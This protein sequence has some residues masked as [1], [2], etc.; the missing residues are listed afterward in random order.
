MRYLFGFFITVG[1]IILL[2]VLLVTGGNKSKVPNTSKTLAS[3]ANSTAVVRL[4]I[5][6]PINSVQDHR[7]SRITVGR[8]NTTYEQLQG[9]DGNVTLLQ[10]YPNTPTSYGTFLRAIALAGFT[11]GDT[12]SAL[13]ND[14]GYCPLGSRFIF[15]LE[16]N[17]QQLERFWST[18]CSGAKS[19]LGNANLIV[20]LFKRQVPDF[21]KMNDQSSVGSFF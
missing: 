2:I 7:A 14:R 20:N 5:D 16:D 8:D 9:Y 10:T 3:Y 1:L 12:A 18:S 13:K 17:G 19:F 11:K 4:T 15:E 6:G 21:N